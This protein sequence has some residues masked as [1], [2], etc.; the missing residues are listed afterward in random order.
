MKKLKEDFSGWIQSMPVTLNHN[1]NQ[2]LDQSHEL[3]M[4]IE[5]LKGKNFLLASGHSDT[6]SRSTLERIN[7]IYHNHISYT[8]F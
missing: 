3:E 4:S 8:D 2:F 1:Q 5:T 7:Q 6:Q